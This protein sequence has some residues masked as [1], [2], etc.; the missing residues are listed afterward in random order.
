[1]SGSVHQ[2]HWNEALKP[3]PPNHKIQKTKPLFRKIEETPE[4]LAEK[5]ETVRDRLRK[6]L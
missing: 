6:P 2:Q 1:M 5:L 3:L 4:Q